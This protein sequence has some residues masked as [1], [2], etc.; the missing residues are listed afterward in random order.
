MRSR[1]ATLR[2]VPGRYSGSP[3]TPG[4]RSLTSKSVRRSRSRSGSP[5]VSGSPKD[6]RHR[7]GEAA[8]GASLSPGTTAS[9][10]FR[11]AGPGDVGDAAHGA[12][13]PAVVEL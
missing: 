4:A 6:D 3:L 10:A 2:T 13:E 9:G 12:G 5:R 7:F 8:V 1:S 11:H